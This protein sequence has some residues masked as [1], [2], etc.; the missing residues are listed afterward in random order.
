[1]ENESVN[2]SFVLFCILF[3]F[4]GSYLH[5]TQRN[6]TKLIKKHYKLQLQK[7]GFTSYKN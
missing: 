7:K 3:I 1:M 5:T 4:Q 2:F 6:K